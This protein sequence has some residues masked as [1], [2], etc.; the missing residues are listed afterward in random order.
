MLPVDAANGLIDEKV[1]FDHA[2]GAIFT[3]GRADGDDLA[4]EDDGGGVGDLVK[5]FFDGLGEGVLR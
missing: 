2:G 1:D 5:G 3:S 4:G